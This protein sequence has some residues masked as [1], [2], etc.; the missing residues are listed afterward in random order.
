[1]QRITIEGLALEKLQKLWEPHLPDRIIRFP[2]VYERIC[3]VFCMPKET[4]KLVLKSME[5]EGM[6]QIVRKQGIRIRKC[7]VVQM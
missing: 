2:D 7:R 1:M 4:A 6:I 5:C 3:P